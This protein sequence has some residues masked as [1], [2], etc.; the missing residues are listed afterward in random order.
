[1]PRDRRAGGLGRTAP[2]L[3]AG[4]L[5]LGAAA[6]ALPAQV[7][8]MSDAEFVDALTATDDERPVDR[9]RLARLFFS[10][11]STLEAG[12]TGVALL[13]ERISARG[14]GQESLR[15]VALQQFERYAAEVDRFKAAVSRLLDDPDSDLLLYR[16][17]MDGHRACWYF[18]RYTRFAETYGADLLSVLSSSEV[19]QRFNAAALQPRVEG[20]VAE[21]LLDQA[22]QREEIAALREELRELE[23][24]IDDLKAIDGSA[25]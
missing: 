1:M 14:P 12:R 4:G 5:A 23:L 24:L 22:R 25:E 11:A 16:A 10:V 15:G 3:L 7:A 19:C 2:W 21:S 13:R 9:K 17:L 20:L 6:G 8:T 18:D